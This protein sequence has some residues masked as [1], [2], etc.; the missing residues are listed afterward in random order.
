MPDKN[1]FKYW[2]LFSFGMVLC[3][4]PPVVATA[5]F[6]PIWRMSSGKSI[7]GMAVILIAI[8][9]IPLWKHIKKA[10][11]NPSAWKIWCLIFVFCAVVKDIVADMYVIA[12]IGLLSSLVACFVFGW[13]KKYRKK[14]DHSDREE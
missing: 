1:R 4:V 5:Q 9:C 2:I 10:F 6:F 7:S 12:L 3:I 14:D 8:S 13:A 11:K